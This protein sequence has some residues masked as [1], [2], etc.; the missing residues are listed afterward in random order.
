MGQIAILYDGPAEEKYYSISP[1]VY[2]MGN[3]VRYLDPTGKEASPIYSVEGELLGTDDQGLQGDAIVMDGQDFTQGMSHG[4]AMAK[5]LGEDG[6]VSEE[7]YAKYR[8][9]Y[10]NLPNRPD[11]DGYLT[12]AEADKWWRGRSG[13]PLYVDQSKTELHGVNTKW[14]GRPRGPNDGKDFL[15]RSYNYSRVPA[16]IKK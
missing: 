12:K 7:A 13:E 5:N 6:F 11:Y 9:N 8:E 4:E 15:I 14:V 10:E 3:P 16:V 2:R 1:Y